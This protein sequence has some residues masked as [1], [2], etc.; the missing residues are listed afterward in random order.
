MVR[1][2][3]IVGPAYTLQS[4][5]ADCQQC[6]NWFPEQYELG[7]GKEREVAS[8][9]PT[10]GLRLLF[11]VGAGP[12]RGA[13]VAKNGTLFVVS[14]TGLYKVAADYTTTLVGTL[15]GANGTPVSMCDNGTLLFIGD[16]LGYTSTISGGNFARITSDEFNGASTTSFQDGY[17]IATST[18]G[19]GQ[20]QIS[21][22]YSGNFDGLSFATAEGAPDGLMAHLSSNRNLWLFGEFSTEIWFNSGNLDFP[23]QRND[24]AFIEFGCAAKYSP[25]KVGNTVVWLGKDSRGQGIVWQAQGFQ[26]KRISTNAME[27]ELAGYATI[28][29]A[30]AWTYVEAGHAF[31]V[32]SFPTANKTWVFDE[33]TQL[34]H[35]RSYF[36]NGETTRHRAMCHAFFN[37]D[38]VVGDH[39]NGNFY[40]LESSAL[41]DNGA[42]IRRV[43]TGPHYSVGMRR[44]TYHS[45]QLDMGVGVGLDGATTVQGHDPHVMM[46]YSD[47]GGHAWSNEKWRSIG[48][49]GRYE[50]RVVWRRLGVSRDRV[51][52]FVITDPVRATILG[53]EADVERLGS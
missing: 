33:A 8:L 14:G 26:P 12:G 24:G 51:F 44:S 38:H 16:N 31:Y 36:S 17:F 46:Q 13:Y 35:E 52:R 40:A 1:L 23:F 34:W 2:K 19:A 6:I 20:F 5:N 7:S 47:D 4:L 42:E 10:P 48:K 41:T 32:L 25:A 45:V 28:S 30:V 53:A 29:D 27:Q 43:R 39:T 18:N 50:T 11:N 49:L 22:L 3:G 37:G 21:D 9:A 15:S